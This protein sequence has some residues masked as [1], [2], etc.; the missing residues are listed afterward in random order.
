MYFPD[1]EFKAAAG[2]DL[3]PQLAG[4]DDGKLFRLACAPLG[5]VFK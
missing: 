3:A 4:I 5:M 2:I 1:G